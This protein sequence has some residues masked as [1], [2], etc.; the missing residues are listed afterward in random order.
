MEQAQAHTLAHPT[1]PTPQRTASG[2]W[3]SSGTPGAKTVNRQGGGGGGGG[4]FGV[5]QWVEAWEAR[6]AQHGSEQPFPHPK[7]T[8]DAQPPP[9][10]PGTSDGGAMASPHPPFPTAQAG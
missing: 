10:Q 4:L 6:R 8:P 2:R 1:G 9:P 7:P 3:L 5:A